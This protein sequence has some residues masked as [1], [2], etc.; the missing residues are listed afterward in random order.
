MAVA[1]RVS[2]DPGAILKLLAD[3]TRLRILALLEREELAVGELSRALGMAQSR[4]SNHLRL[5]REAGLLGE[6]HA[7]TKTFL[8]LPLEAGPGLA[9]RLWAEL[10]GELDGLPEH[11]ADLVRLERVLAEREGQGSFFDRY[12][13]EWDK[14]AGGFATGLGRERALTH[15]LPD[16]L[17]VADLGCGTGYLAQAL[18]GQAARL[19]CVDASEPMLAEAE[20]R[21]GRNG[22]ARATEVEFRQGDLD[23]L[24]IS[25]AEVDGALAGMVL[26][27]LPAPDAALA[28]MRRILKPGGSAVVLELLPHRETWMRDA[29]GD[30]HLGL[31]P[32]D[33]VAAFQR[34]G[35]E[36]VT[37]DPVSDRYQPERPEEHGGGAA[38]LGL[39]LVRGRRPRVRTSSHARSNR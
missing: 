2:T 24:P 17:V 8:H 23:A 28:E 22:D 39:Y 5:I 33:V 19:I 4:V 6:R 37:L 14:R 21:L 13:G 10:R 16:G 12:A 26:H 20:R 35:L 36:Q 38:D 15:L 31:E 34:A 18:L 11:A 3:P 27:H 9:G 1:E 30:R 32:S 29:L 7:G 25:D